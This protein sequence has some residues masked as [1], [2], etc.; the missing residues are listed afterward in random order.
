MQRR[1]AK[2]PVK[3]NKSGESSISATQA[4][5]IMGLSTARRRWGLRRVITKFT[6]TLVASL[7]LA[8]T[9]LAA[10]STCSSPRLG[11]RDAATINLALTDVLEKISLFDAAMLQYQGGADL[12]AIAETGYNTVEAVR[13]ASARVSN[14]T[15]V[16]SAAE[17]TQFA[18]LVERL[19]V[20][21]EGLLGRV[22]SQTVNFTSSG[23]CSDIYNCV[24]EIGQ[25]VGKLM[26]EVAA[27][28]PAE[29]KY[30][31]PATIQRFTDLFASTNAR[32]QA[33]AAA[34]PRPAGSSVSPGPRPFHSTA[35]PTV[36][37]AA[38]L[39]PAGPGAATPSPQA[40]A[41]T[42]V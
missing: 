4:I 27:K 5:G 36:T 31:A 26:T 41:A 22:V 18:P 20:A 24:N 39:P 8:G 28:F 1:T 32:L 12:T 30:P 37:G 11:R 15:A 3:D 19:S 21:G 6:S 9:G 13:G 23:M 25:G 2:D 34:V 33:C 10:P 42:S 29:A 7:A 14:T 17:A 35:P 40:P 38:V 16:A